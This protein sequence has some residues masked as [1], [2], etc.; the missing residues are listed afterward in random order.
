MSIEKTRTRNVRQHIV[1]ES[2]GPV[3]KTAKPLSRLLADVFD[4]LVLSGLIFYTIQNFETAKL[5]PKVLIRHN[6]LLIVLYFYFILTILPHQFFGQSFGQMLFGVRL[7]TTGHSK[8]SFFTIMARDILRP[9]TLIFQAPLWNKNS[10]AW[11]DNM[12]HTMIAELR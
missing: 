1:N 6:F 10:R 8:P 11:Y 5:L 4:I 3:I 2:S 7:L 9:T 12:L